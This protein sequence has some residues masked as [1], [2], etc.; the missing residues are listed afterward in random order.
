MYQR[1]YLHFLPNKSPTDPSG[2]TF[3]EGTK[4]S[5]AAACVCASLYSEISADT[6]SSAWPVLSQAAA[7]ARPQRG[8]AQCD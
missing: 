2:D 5:G 1:G 3:C 6:F 7:H 8:V 4:H